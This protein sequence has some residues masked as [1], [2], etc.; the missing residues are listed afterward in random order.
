[1]PIGKYDPAALAVAFASADLHQAQARAIKLAMTPRQMQLNYFYSHYA[2][3]QYDNRVVGW[4]G[5]RVPKLGERDGILRQTW[6]PPGYY[7]QGHLFDMVPLEHRKPDVQVHLVREV[8][9]GFTDMMF[10]DEQEPI[11]SVKDD[12]ATTEW[13]GNM[14]KASSYWHTW[15]EV[16]N[17]AGAMGSAALTFKFLN[18]RLMLE[19]HDP[20]WCTPVVT[21]QTI[22]DCSS[23]EIKYMYPIEMLDEKGG[24]I[25]EVWHWYRRVIDTASDTTYLPALVDPENPIVWSPDPEKTVH[26]G[27]GFFPGVWVQNTK[28]VGRLDG[29][30]DCKGVFDNAEMN[31]RLLT[32]AATGAVHNADATLHVAT[33]DA[34]LRD[35]KKGSDNAIRTE[36]GGA[37]GYVEMSGSGTKAAVEVYQEIDT[38][39]LRATRY[40]RLQDREGGNMTAEEVRRRCGPM[41]ASVKKRRTH[42]TQT[43]ILPATEKIIRATRQLGERQTVDPVTG[44]VLTRTT[45]AMP[46][47]Q[48]MASGDIDNQSIDAIDAVIDVRWPPVIA[49][50]PVDAQAAAGAASTARQAGIIDR[51]S[52]IEYIAGSFGIDDVAAVADAIDLELAAKSQALESE[53]LGGAPAPGVDPTAAPP[54]EA[55]TKAADEALNGLQ[56]EALRAFAADAYNGVMLRENVIAQASMAFPRASRAMLEA[57]IPHPKPA[58]QPLPPLGV[59]PLDPA[60]V[61]GAPPPPAPAPPPPPGP[62]PAP[63]GAPPAPPAPGAM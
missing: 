56:I 42:W 10:G 4:N 54:P 19:E 49:P 2:A 59:P 17:L 8:V 12:D 29:D 16:R 43:A 11:L 61:P 51:R 38:L 3:E 18:G 40:V 5:L 22:G 50:S 63:S 48:A 13:I 37:V 15:G 30:P 39:S 25:V 58:P 47:P 41:I 31:D 7:D 57:A 21:D 23:L 32:Q 45:V 9:T 33:N 24:G 46:L 26:H 52:A 62:E 27:L 36:Q 20:R 55:D 35:L 53:L 44:H 28:S 60:A 1:M 34:K 14:A 6:L